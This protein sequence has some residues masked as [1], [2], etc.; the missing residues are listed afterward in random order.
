MFSGVQASQNGSLKEE[1]TGSEES[2][3]STRLLN[4]RAS[5]SVIDFRTYEEYTPLIGN[6]SLNAL[7]ALSL[8]EFSGILE[9]EVKKTTSGKNLLSLVKRDIKIRLAY[10]NRIKELH[11]ICT[12]VETDR[13]SA[14]LGEEWS[15]E[16][17]KENKN[18]EFTTIFFKECIKEL[19]KGS[20]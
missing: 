13:F 4:E 11:E 1:V 12:S 16:K 5:A 9:A 20:M 15:T 6:Y 18:F 14:N 8:D 10:K 19:Q 3:R 7:A 17:I 2:S